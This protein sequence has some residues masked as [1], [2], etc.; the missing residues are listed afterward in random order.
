VGFFRAREPFLVEL[1]GEGGLNG[2]G[3]ALVSPEAASTYVRTTL[4]PLVLG[5]SPQAT[6]RLWRR[7]MDTAGFDRRGIA[8]MASG[9][10][11]MALH[12]LA[13]REQGV[14]VSAL[15]GG[16][17]RTQV[18]T[19]ASG[20][21]FKPD[22]HPYREYEREVEAHLGA[23]FKAIKPRAGFSPRDDGDMARAL[24]ALIGPD[25]ALMVDFNQG[26]TA[27]A[28][29][30][31][32]H[33]MREAGLLWIEEPVPP[34]ALDAY[35]QVARAVPVAIA[36]GEAWASM[37]A[38]REALTRGA[39]A[40][41][42]PDLAFCGGFTGFRRIQA[43]AEAFDV[44][45]VPHVWGTAVNF[46]AALQANA[47][48][49]AY[50]GGARMPFPFMEYDVTPNPFFHELGIPPLNADGTTTIPATPGLGL[51]LSGAALQPWLVDYWSVRQ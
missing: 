50:R 30:D 20:P 23:G 4:A 33:R 44:P 21:F 5:E 45:V 43:L 6:G 22:G 3:E 1:L 12:D 7:M 49:P 13:A 31:A 11:D 35:H 42:Q 34:E 38:V 46:H 39:V 36:A 29:I 9:A 28:A 40:I 18:P 41:V 47:V 32:A 14:P 2:W 27:A 15:L 17:L 16:S 10:V 26:Y 48:L 8:V 37:A 51:T 24:R 25:V 19:Y